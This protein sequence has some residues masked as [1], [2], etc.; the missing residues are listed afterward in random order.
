MVCTEC[1]ARLMEGDQFCP[2]CGARVIKE[3]RCPDCGEVLRGGAKF[4]PGCGRAV[5]GRQSVP[6][7]PDETLDIPIEA[8][9]RNILSETA[10]EIKAGRTAGQ[11]SGGKASAEKEPAR[12]SLSG[13]A[14]AGRASQGGAPSRNPSARKA[15][16]RSMPAGSSTSAGRGGD[17]KSPSG[18]VPAKKKKAT[19]PAPPA[20][21]K[22]PAYRE[23]VWE[24]DD[25]WE[26]DGWDDDEEGI[27]VITIMTVVVGCILLIVVA[28]LGFHFYRQYVPKD[29]EKAAGQ[30]AGEEQEEREG[31]DTG[32]DGGA[33]EEAGGEDGRETYTL[34]IDSNVNVREKPS[35]SSNKL[36]VAQA[37]ET[38][39][40][41]GT[42]GDGTWYEIVLEDGTTGYVFKDYVSV[43]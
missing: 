21:R 29:Y 6:E 5:G 4:C 12:R 28:V 15:A 3:R 13:G 40:C 23:E 26:D 7:E 38:Y 41:Y 19:V 2:K 30:E 34:T 1:G 22:R 11:G 39:T 35:T 31:Q 14:S 42:A 36:K 10:A 16:D 25:G 33:E 17:T 20:G 43:R 24:E 8:I 18:G 37:G 27:D 32:D 9:E